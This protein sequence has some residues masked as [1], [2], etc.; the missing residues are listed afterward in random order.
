MNSVYILGVINKIDP[1][2]LALLSSLRI[3]RSFRFFIPFLFLSFPHRSFLSFFRA[4]RLWPVP[5]INEHLLV[6]LNNKQ[7]QEREKRRTER[8]RGKKRRRRG[9]ERTRG[10]RIV[11]SIVRLLYLV[12]SFCGSLSHPSPSPHV[13]S[14]L[15][16]SKF[17]FCM[18]HSSFSLS[19]S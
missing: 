4:A 15:S 18:S 7:E 12:P 6:P 11:R 2:R 9:K 13:S 19:H 10:W 16:S 14:S 1:E 3:S 5:S 8:K 17:T